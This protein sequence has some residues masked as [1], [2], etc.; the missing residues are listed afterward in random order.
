VSSH[1]F[2]HLDSAATAARHP[3]WGVP[4]PHGAAGRAAATGVWRVWGRARLLLCVASAMIEARV[5]AEL[6][7]FVGELGTT[8]LR[9]RVALDDTLDRDLGIGSLERVELL[10]RLEQAFAI[11]LPDAVLE[12]ADTVR[13]LVSAV[14]AGTRPAAAAA[15]EPARPI[16][17]GVPAPDSA[18]TLVE[19]LRWH[20]ERDPA[21][22]H[23]VLRLDDDSEQ[24]ITYGQLWER[25]GGVAAG[26]RAR[27]VPPGASVALMLRTEPD[28]F[29]AFFGVLRAGAVPVPVY[30]PA[31]PGRLAEYAARQV[32][33]ATTPRATR[34]VAGPSASSFS[35]ACARHTVSARI[36]AYT[37]TTTTSAVLPSA[38][39][40]PGMLANAS[41][42]RM[43]KARNGHA[44]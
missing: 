41:T 37:R 39:F 9:G 5:L 30:P 28:F 13:G 7:A 25:A 34:T 31:R 3:Q 36:N 4:S 19:V 42:A 35:R 14:R 22:V 43:V 10:A 27:G 21:R 17:A 2:G 40:P 8:P 12:E 24:S 29:A 26:L 20:A 16:A 11:R 6:D 18:R 1:N 23:V 33:T 38:R 44:R 15:V 32:K